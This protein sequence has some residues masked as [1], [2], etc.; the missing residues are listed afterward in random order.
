MNI[1]KLYVYLS[2]VP[3]SVIKLRNI[4]KCLP[5]SYLS[6]CKS[7]LLLFTV[8]YQFY[9]CFIRNIQYLLTCLNSILLVF[10]VLCF[11][12]L[13]TRNFLDWITFKILFFIFIYNYII[14]FYPKIFLT[15]NGNYII[16]IIISVCIIKFV[17]FSANIN[18][19]KLIFSKNASNTFIFNYTTIILKIRITFLYYLIFSKNCSY[20]LMFLFVFNVLYFSVSNTKI[21][22]DWISFKKR[23]LISVYNF[24]LLFYPN[25]FL[26]FNGNHMI[27]FI[28]LLFI[29]KFAM[30]SANL[31]HYKLIF[32]KS[33]FNTYIFNS[34][35]I[36]LNI[37]I[38]FLHYIF[39]SSDC[40]KNLMIC[41]FILMLC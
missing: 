40:I 16:S 3:L 32:A 27:L 7:I 6:Q 5:S 35:T 4:K 8:I 18:H 41:N 22:L 33:A 12:V 37:R 38:T 23:F 29:T 15:L 21:C 36:I 30:S 26:T 9:A 34:T 2:I 13:N 10:Y 31:N 11:S 28:R 17:I 14:H 1:N 39:F 19:C 20:K 24:I 25:I